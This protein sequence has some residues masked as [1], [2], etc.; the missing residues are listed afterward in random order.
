MD[1]SHLMSNF[2]TLFLLKDV[3]YVAAVILNLYVED[4]GSC[5]AAVPSS[6]SLLIPHLIYIL[7]DLAT[8]AAHAPGF[9]NIFA[10]GNIHPANCW[11]GMVNVERGPG[12]N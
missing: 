8:I 4:R 3:I 12:S 11:T 9:L 6:I 2:Q 5:Q 1:V 7:V 10:S